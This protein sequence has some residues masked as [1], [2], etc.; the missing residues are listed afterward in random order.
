[1]PFNPCCCFCFLKKKSTKKN[2]K[3][4]KTEL[5]IDCSHPEEEVEA[6][7]L[8]VFENIPRRHQRLNPHNVDGAYTKPG[9]SGRF[10][11]D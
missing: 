8:G 4:I 9:L 11:R 3:K 7:F 10:W 2:H 5:T 1:M 6:T